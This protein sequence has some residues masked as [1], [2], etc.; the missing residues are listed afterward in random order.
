MCTSPPSYGSP[1][2]STAAPRPRSTFGSPASIKG[3]AGRASKSTGRRDSYTRFTAEEEAML[4][5]G[6]RVF[7]VGNWKKIL[8]SYRFHW[9]R[10]AVDLKDKYRNMTRA[11]MRRINAAAATGPQSAAAS[12]RQRLPLP[13]PPVRRRSSVNGGGGGIEHDARFS[14]AL[15]RVGSAP[16]PKRASSHVATHVARMQ[17]SISPVTT[18]NTTPAG[19]VEEKSLAP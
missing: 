11:K 10:T 16:L 13:L 12:P 2:A 15:P 14:Y 5:D 18:P 7:G 9:K 4:L 17:M 6:V 8:N 19:S 3:V 1:P